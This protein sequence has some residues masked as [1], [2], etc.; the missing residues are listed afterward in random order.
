MPRSAHRA[1]CLALLLAA[2]AL[3]AASGAAATDPARDTGDAPQEEG[4]DLGLPEDDEAGKLDFD[5]GPVASWLGAPFDRVLGPYDA[6][7]DYLR[8]EWKFDY[9]WYYS[10]V[11]QA[12]SQGHHD[13]T[14][15]HEISFIGDWTVL[16]N[17]K[18]GKSGVRWWYLH[19]YTYG[20]TSTSEFGRAA[21]S[22]TFTNGG[23]GDSGSTDVLGLLWYEH[24]L[25]DE[26]LVLV[27]GKLDARQLI[28]R[29]RYV[30][31]DRQD[32]MNHSF[33]NKVVQPVFA[34][35]ALGLF[36]SYETDQMWVSLLM[37]DG[38]GH[39]KGID[40]KSV[41]NGNFQY[42]GEMGFI[43]Q[44]Q[45]LG[46][47]RYRF[48]VFLNDK[49]QGFERSGWGAA[50]AFDQDLDDRYSLF[51]RVSRS[52][53]QERT[54]KTIASTGL[55]VRG[56]GPWAQDTIGLGVSWGDP[57]KSDPRNE[58]DQYSLEAF[59]NMRITQRIQFTPDLQFLIRPSRDRGK[60]FVAVGGGRVYIQF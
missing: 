19:Q 8:E 58:R 39:E 12:G 5:Y 45:S 28:S 41:D 43:T 24:W 40:F 51:L 42:A 10:P 49:T 23:P 16:E 35:P 18:W 26:S 59:W 21:G 25:I 13:T 6:L 56:V 3:A 46:E 50:L 2:L 4:V 22:S 44:P 27:A 20:K 15:H 37:K 34:V 38:D 11:F 30:G 33:F 9:V 52:E 57:S 31:D 36:A 17:E 32:F 29:L 54:L 53:D 48:S 1:T 47:G 14:A 60:D 7:R 55:I